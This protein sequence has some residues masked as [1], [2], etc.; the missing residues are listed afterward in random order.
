MTDIKHVA[1]AA[2]VMAGLAMTPVAA[3]NKDTMVAAQ[4]RMSVGQAVT[5]TSCI[6]KGQRADTFILTH[7]AD[8][9]AHPASMGRVVYWLDTVKPLRAHVGHQVRVMGTISEVKMEEME[10]K[11]GDDGTG[12]W[13][14]EIEGPGKDVRVTPAQA[15]VSTAGRKSGQNDIKTTLV[16]LKVSDVT[17]VAA[18]CPAM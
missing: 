7:T 2:F 17:M 9:P 12:G 11:T 13:S 6:E 15:G 16:K 1:A 10:V 5:L 3:Q 4:N 18:S 8:V 14:V